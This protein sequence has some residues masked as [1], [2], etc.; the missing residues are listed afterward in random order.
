MNIAMTSEEAFFKGISSAHFVKFLVA[1]KIQIRPLDGGD[2]GPIT[3]RAHVWKG[4][5][6][7]TRCRAID[8]A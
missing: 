2:L 8:G 6:A 1:V 7:L 4:H 3:S 5:G